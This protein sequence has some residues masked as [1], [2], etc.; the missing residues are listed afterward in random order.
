MKQSISAFVLFTLLVTASFAAEQNHVA[1]S[2][3]GKTGPSHWADLSPEFRLCREGR[4]QSPVDLGQRVDAALPE[5]GFSYYSPP[6]TITNNGHTI[7]VTAGHNNKLIMG[8]DRF[9]LMQVHFHFPSEHTLNGKH[10]PLE[11]HFVHK[12]QDGHLA[13]V[14][15]MFHLDKPNHSIQA[16]WEQ[17]PDRIGETAELKP[18]SGSCGI[19]PEVGACGLLPIE[20]DYVR[21]N[22]SLTTPPCTE[23]VTWIVLKQVMSVSKEQADA[24]RKL[25]KHPNNRPVQPLNGRV[26]LE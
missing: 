22:G 14:A 23:G 10:F 2:Y 21:Y 17:V 16:L 3:T 13:V 6:Q 11:A 24:F 4:N 7:V 20:K 19:A 25:M 26:I 15:V 5:L 8:D 12:D 18:P 1:W 9:D